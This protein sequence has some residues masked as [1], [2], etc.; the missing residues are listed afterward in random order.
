[1]TDFKYKTVRCEW[2]IVIQD[3]DQYG[4]STRDR[5]LLVSHPCY[6]E[7]KADMWRYGYEHEFVKDRWI[8]YDANHSFQMLEI[9]YQ[10][11]EVK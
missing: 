9:Q 4:K 6:E 10:E 7:A 5:R 3:V 1:M 8:P 11:V 2:Q